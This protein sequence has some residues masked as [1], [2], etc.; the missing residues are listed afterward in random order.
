MAHDVFRAIL[1]KPNESTH[2]LQCAIP[3]REHRHGRR[4]GSD[5]IFG[6]AQELGHE[7]ETLR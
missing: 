3:R 2:P 4:L 1:A 7:I 6:L 5:P